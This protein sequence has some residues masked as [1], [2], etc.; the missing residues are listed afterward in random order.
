[1]TVKNED[2]KNCKKLSNKTVGKNVKNQ[3]SL[4]NDRNEKIKKS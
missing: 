3:T 1:M 2:Y 4:F